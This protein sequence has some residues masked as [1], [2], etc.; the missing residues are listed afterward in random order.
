MGDITLPV[1]IVLIVSL[2]PIIG[3][4][5][6]ECIKRNFELKQI[7]YRDNKL[8]QIEKYL[9]ECINDNKNSPAIKISEILKEKM[10]SAVKSSGNSARGINPA[11][12]QRLINNGIA[13]VSSEI[14]KET[15]KQRVEEINTFLQSL[16]HIYK[17]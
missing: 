9:W 12:R 6:V 15:M 13:R 7:Q 16:I 10:L 5:T 17:K 11:T 3:L 4:I 1:L 8:S 14:S 2:A